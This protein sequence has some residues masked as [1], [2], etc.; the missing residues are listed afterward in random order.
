MA[1][2]RKSAGDKQN[3][4]GLHGV[5]DYCMLLRNNAARLRD[6][7]F[8]HFNVTARLM[9]INKKFGAVQDQLVAEESKNQA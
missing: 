5:R 6:R 9:R 1:V 8:T 4:Y 2:Q 3:L 7:R